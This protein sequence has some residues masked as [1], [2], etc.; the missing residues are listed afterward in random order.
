MLLRDLD[1]A[2]YWSGRARVGEYEVNA[3][4]GYLAGAPTYSL[5]AELAL[6]RPVCGALPAVGEFPDALSRTGAHRRS[7]HAEFSLAYARMRAERGDIAG[8][9]GQRAKALIETAHARVPPPAL[10]VQRE[11]I[12]EQTR[13]EKVPARFVGIPTSPLDPVAWVDDLRAAIGEA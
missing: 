10:G 5:M 13:L 7:L 4:L 6:N 2:L 1:G 12:V 8:A 11:R 3:L 9:V